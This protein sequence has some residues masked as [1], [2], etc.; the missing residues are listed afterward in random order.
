M[1]TKAEAKAKKG[2]TFGSATH[3]NKGVSGTWKKKLTVAEGEALFTQLGRIGMTVVK[4]SWCEGE[5]GLK[6]VRCKICKKSDEPYMMVQCDTCEGYYHLAC[7][8]PPLKRMPKKNRWKGWQCAKCSESDDVESEVVEPVVAFTEGRSRRTKAGVNPRITEDLGFRAGKAA[9]GP[10][11]AQQQSRQAQQPRQQAQQTQ[12]PRQTQQSK[13]SDREKEKP[14]AAKRPAKSADTILSVEMNGCRGKNVRLGGK[15][16]RSTKVNG[17]YSFVKRSY[18]K[19]KMDFETYAIFYTKT[20]NAWN[21]GPDIGSEIV[22]G[23]V[24][25]DAETPDRTTGTWNVSDGQQFQL[26]PLIQI[27]GQYAKT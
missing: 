10:A 26:E 8:D 20:D 19:H 17:K 18:N 27:T 25:D 6:A 3:F 1:R 15:Y 16:V 24:V 21:V 12:Q 22:F 23:W 13:K 14:K 4:P 11:Q 5:D 2:G 7:H 9:G